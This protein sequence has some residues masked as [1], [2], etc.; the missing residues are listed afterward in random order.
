[1]LRL[2]RLMWKYGPALFIFGLVLSVWQI[3]VSVSNV[4]AQVLPG[5]LL[6]FDTLVAQW[7]ILWSNTYQTL[8][9]TVLGFAIAL[10]GGVGCA[11]LL[12]ASPLFKRAIYPLLIASQTIPLV[13]IAPLLIVLFGFDLVPKLIVVWLVCF[14]P[15]VVAGVDGFGATEPEMTSLFESWGANGWQIFWKLRL[16]SALPYL[17]SGIRIAVTYSVAGAVLAEYVASERGLGNYILKAKFYNDRIYAAIV[18]MALFSVGLF[19]AVNLVQ[20]LTMPWWYKMRDNQ[21]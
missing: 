9:E 10:A 20:H 3:A 21:S 16:P 17:F 2:K 15:I 4:R 11:I 14:F 6:I 8:I 12:D 13:G 19:V 1:M 7:P 18:M 5:P